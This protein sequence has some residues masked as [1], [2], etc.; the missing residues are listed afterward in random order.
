MPFSADHH[1]APSSLFSPQGDGGV[2]VVAQR[3][4]GSS[5]DSPLGRRLSEL[6]REG[7]DVE[8]AAAEALARSLEEFVV[9]DGVD[10]VL[11]RLG[12]DVVDDQVVAALTALS[13]ADVVDVLVEA[14]VDDVWEGTVIA[15]L[16]QLRRLAAESLTAVGLEGASLLD[17]EG[18]RLTLSAL[19]DYIDE[20]FW[21]LGVVTPVAGKLLDGVASSLRLERIEDVAERLRGQ[22]YRWDHAATEARDSLAYYNN[23]VND[24]LIDEADPEGDALLVA[25]LGPDDRI[26]RPFCDALVGRAYR[27]EDL[28]QADNGVRGRPFR[29]SHGGYRCRHRTSGVPDDDAV[30]DALGLE[31]GTIEDVRRANAAARRRGSKR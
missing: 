10:A 8:D 13:L 19:E 4:F 16:P 11:A 27:R 1:R 25:Y 17:S 21:R 18:L 2:R 22:G 9:G 23:F 7:L 3:A 15:A 30:L 20:E 29:H 14:G 12:S 28:D 26:T 5:G 31:R 24:A 6:L